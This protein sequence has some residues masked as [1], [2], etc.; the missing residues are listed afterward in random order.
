VDTCV[1]DLL[2]PH[3]P[4]GRLTLLPLLRGHGGGDAPDYDVAANRATR[5]SLLLPTALHGAY[6]NSRAC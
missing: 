3:A 5:L 1:R 6:L 4:D 2:G